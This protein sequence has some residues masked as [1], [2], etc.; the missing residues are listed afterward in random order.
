MDQTTHFYGRDLV[1]AWP[2]TLAMYVRSSQ[3]KT[4]SDVL[5]NLGY[6]NAPL[7]DTLNTY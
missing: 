3:V 6:V 5:I 2:N 7:S 4:G 1:E